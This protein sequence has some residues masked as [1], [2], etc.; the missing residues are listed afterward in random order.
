MSP[1]IGPSGPLSRERIVTAAIE[2]ADEAGLGAVMLVQDEIVEFAHTTRER[3]EETWKQR[4]EDTTQLTDKMIERGTKIEKENRER[5]E[6]F[7]EGRRQRANDWMKQSE[8]RFNSG[9][10]NVLSYAHIPSSAELDSLGKKINTL[11][12]KV[13]NIRKSQEKSVDAAV[14]EMVETLKA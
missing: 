5:M 11:G 12:R 2:L 10:E 13:D 4:R 14:E 1:R 7:F 9:M 8:K 6:H 3:A